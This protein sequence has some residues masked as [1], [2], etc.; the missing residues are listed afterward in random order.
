MFWEAGQGWTGVG[1][2]GQGWAS[3]PESWEQKKQ[4]TKKQINKKKDSRDGLIRFFPWG[5]ARVGGGY[6]LIRFG[7]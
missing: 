2:A 5:P 1:K 4:K 6:L 3:I 7:H